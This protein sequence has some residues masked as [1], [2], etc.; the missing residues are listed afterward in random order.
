M[1]LGRVIAK[2]REGGRLEAAEALELAGA[3]TAAPLL[4]AAQELTETGFGALVTYSPKVFIPLTRLC[5]DVCHYCTFA[6]TPSHL[7]APYLSIEEVLDIARAGAAAGGREALFTLGDQPEK[8]YRAAREVLAAAGFRTTIEYLGEA[9]RRVLAETPLLPHLNPGVMTE[10]E[11]RELRPRAASMGLMLETVSERLSERGGPHFG[12]PD[13]V[14]A[15]RLATLEAAGR[16]QVPFTT[17]ILVG[18]G[19]TRAERIEALLAIRDSHERHGHIQEVIIQNFR[20]K[21][22]TAMAGSVEPSLDEQLW[23]IAAARLVLGAGMSIQAPPNLRPDGLLALLQAG[24]NDWGGVS[25][26]TRDHV[27]PEAPWPEL[28]YLSAQTERA[29]KVLRERFPVGPAQAREPGRWLAPEIAQRVRA[30][31]NG[32][33]LPS[34]GIWFAGQDGSSPA[35]PAAQVLGQR[36]PRPSAAVARGLAAL[37][38]GESV[39][40][41]GIE[42]LFQAQGADEAAVLAAADAAR[43]ELAGETVTFVM[44]CNINYTN[45]C[46]YHCSFCAFAKGSSRG[47]RDPAY[48]M[49]PEDIAQRAE[50]AWLRGATEVCLQGGIHPGFDGD[51][52]LDILAAVKAAVPDIHVHAF[53]PLEI[54]HGARSLGMSLDAYLRR[55]AQAGLGTIPGTAAEILDDEVRRVIC[56]DKLNTAEW[57]EVLRTAHLQGIR[58][59]ATI[60]FG[61]VD[62][63]HHWARHLLRLRALQLETR[64]ITEFVPLPFVHMEAP[65]WRR[66]QSRRG[67]SYR[68]ARLMHA[69]ARLVFGAAIPN[70]QVSWAKLGKE[71]AAD[72][73]QAGANDLGGV[74]MHESITR[75][76]GGEHGQL[77]DAAQIAELCQAIG[78]PVAQRT[79]LYGPV[80]VVRA[81]F[82]QPL[83]PQPEMY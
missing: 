13:K 24:V 43:R 25:P 8:R 58:S 65:M 51:T 59:T 6:T 72:C 80:P 83:R 74:L 41:A 2:A 33:G 42:T 31:A 7:S 71:R 53:S 76:A 15:A 79:T 61:H 56:P 82:T 62:T 34:S 81:P 35:R 64:G 38:R 78:R 18:I 16:A 50:E 4:A 54:A 21:P 12:S 75:A 9:A 22:G 27:N 66:R 46:R 30:D 32:M 55:L 17:G 67:P 29:G 45:I 36:S 77:L 1:S 52:Y 14:P 40:E 48:L 20:A 60:M 49:D 47:P 23:T 19:E 26:V 5:R 69:V 68:E 28:A 73:L 10:A 11:L 39:S 37:G 3:E 70:I 44:N 57:L 63:P